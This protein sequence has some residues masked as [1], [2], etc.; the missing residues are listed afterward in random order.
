MKTCPRCWSLGRRA[1]KPLSEYRKDASRKDG[2]QVYCKLCQSE[3]TQQWG[4]RNAKRI[5]KLKKQQYME[6]P[7]KFKKRTLA[8]RKKYPERAKRLDRRNV[9]LAKLRRA[10][11]RKKLAQRG[12][13]FS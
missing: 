4:R 6:T 10:E 12:S 5:L 13:N 9:G 2:R 11:K 7:G 1:T 8:W 3:L